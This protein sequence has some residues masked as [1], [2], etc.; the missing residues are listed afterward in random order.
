M[1]NLG[2]YTE[3]LSHSLVAK[4]KEFGFHSNNNKKA[5]AGFGLGSDMIQYKGTEREQSFSGRR[6]G[7]HPI[8]LNSINHYTFRKMYLIDHENCGPGQGRMA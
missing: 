3:T 8:M 7:T 4:C 6:G 1:R 5:L 2:I